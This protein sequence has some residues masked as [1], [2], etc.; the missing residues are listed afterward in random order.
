MHGWWISVIL[1]VVNTNALMAVATPGDPTPRPAQTETGS[2]AQE[3][4][5]W[6]TEALAATKAKDKARVRSF[7]A[8]LA[9]PEHQRWFTETFGTEEG[10]RLDAVYVQWLQE[11][12]NE[13]RSIFEAAV[14]SRRTNLEVEVYEKGVGTGAGLYGA[15][16]ES[17][18]RPTAL[19]VVDGKNPG[20]KYSL[21]IGD[22]VDVAGGFRY[23]PER[24]LRQLSKAPVDRVRQGGNV[25]L[26]TLMTKV[27]PVYPPEAIAKHLTGTVRLHVVTAVDGT[28]KELDVVSGDPIL[29]KAALE[30][31]KQWRYREVRL[32][33]KAVEVDS[34]VD[35]V[36]Q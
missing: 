18:E 36:F 21:R 3:L 12:E 35:V 33:G 25:R 29:A 17:M 5:T 20:Q 14:D 26:A 34:T 13:R 19:Y 8:A 16:V 31:V 7:I 11:P 4:K 1:L 15:T 10:S 27:N 23:V 30:A 9:V 32:D 28:V 22:F 6:L 24:V 2:K